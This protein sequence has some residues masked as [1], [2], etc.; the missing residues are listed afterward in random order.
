MF[1][2]NQ[3]SRARKHTLV[4]RPSNWTLRTSTPKVFDH[5]VNVLEGCVCT[6]SQPNYV[7]DNIGYVIETGT[8]IITGRMIMDEMV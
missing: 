7:V 8:S 6:Q 1:P 3:N 5:C 2:K 4:F